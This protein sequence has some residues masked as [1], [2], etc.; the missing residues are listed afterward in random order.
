MRDPGERL[1]EERSRIPRALPRRLG[2]LVRRVPRDAAKQ[3]PLSVEP[4][5]LPAVSLLP[6]ADAG[7]EQEAVN[8][9][10]GAA[11]PAIEREELFHA[12]V[13]LGTFGTGIA[14][15]AIH[16]ASSGGAMIAESPRDRC[17]ARLTTR[18]LPRR[19]ARDAA[20]IGEI[21]DR[22]GGPP[23]SRSA[24]RAGSGSLRS[25]DSVS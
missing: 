25:V 17:R 5:I 13:V 6:A 1:G 24:P 3:L 4:R 21:G 16:R 12:R 23:R 10:L 11:P 20:G 2:R 19:E 14:L 7:E 9:L 18:S 22:G 8:A 15:A